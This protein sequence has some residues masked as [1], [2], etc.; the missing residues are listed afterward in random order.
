VLQ[1]L[2][3]GG[4]LGRLR[5]HVLHAPPL[6]PSEVN[7]TLR[8]LV[9]RGEAPDVASNTALGT[10]A[11]LPIEHAAAGSRSIEA[12]VAAA[13]LGWAKTCE[14]EY[15]ALAR[16][17]ECPLLTRDARLQRGVAGLI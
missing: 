12:T 7:S 15:I 2:L 1:I 17:L 4:D 8:E 10:L 11:T 13:Q 14:A 6:M 3:A 5:G 9:W 16:R